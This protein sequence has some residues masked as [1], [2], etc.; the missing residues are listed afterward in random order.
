MDKSY[1][2]NYLKDYILEVGDRII[3]FDKTLLIDSHALHEFLKSRAQ[4]ALEEF[5]RNSD[6]LGGCGQEIAMQTLLADLTELEP[7]EEEKDAEAKYQK[8]M[9]EYQ[10]NINWMGSDE[11]DDDGD[12]NSKPDFKVIIAGSRDFNNY[13]VLCDSCENF[14]FDIKSDH[15]I[16]I[17]S[18]GARGGDLLGQRYAEEKGLRIERY[19]AEWD[20]YGRSAGVRRNWIMAEKADALIAFWNGE[21]HGTKNMIDIAEKK[22]LIVRTIMV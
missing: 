18:G 1:Y 9:E 20:K 10:K 5:E 7:T 13:D 2:Y 15:D 19:L 8:E 4:L 21:S 3:G 6:L 22:G 12:T 11:F 17:L 14:L 16:I